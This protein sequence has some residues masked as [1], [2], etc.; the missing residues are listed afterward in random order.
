MPAVDLGGLRAKLGQKGRLILLGLLAAAAAGGVLWQ[1]AHSRQSARKLES[2]TTAV[3]RRAVEIRIPATGSIKPITP[4]N[5]SPTQSGR[6]SRLFVD[7]GD[8]VKEGQVLARMDD[9]NLRGPLLT[10]QGNLEAA[11]A[12]LRKMQ[13]G[14]RP[15]EIN[16]ARANLKDAEAQ[17]IAIR[18]TYLSNV[19]LYKAGAVARVG[20]D[21]TRSQYLSMQDHIKSLRAQLD[22]VEAGFRREDIEAARGQVLQSQGALETIRTQIDDTVIRAPFS[23]VITQKYADVGAFVTPTTSASATSSA[24]SSS[25]FALAGKL[26]GM[27]NVSEA[28][29]GSIYPGQPVE[30]Q[31]DAYPGKIFHGKVRLIAPESVVIQNVTSFQVRITPVEEAHS[32]PLLSGMNFTANF[33]VGTHPNALLIPT[34]SIVSREGGTGVFVLSPERKPLF[35][36]VRVGSTAGAMTEVLTGLKAG[37]RVFLSFPGQRQPNAR[38]VQSSS[39][40]QQQGGGGRQIR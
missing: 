35:R 21:A 8:K 22:L 28:D 30:L 37:E 24:T 11:R 38:P 34:A 17:M 31:V 19:S 25:I 12:N 2:Q 7:Q 3:I 26:E 4:V 6:I 13:N 5:I 18:S 9:S 27:A 23:G 36:H 16:Q 39:P 10:A 32:P 33:L 14:N 40:F 29:I 1:Q 15:Q 20:F